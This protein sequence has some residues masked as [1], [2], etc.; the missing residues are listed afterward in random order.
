MGDWE[1][2]LEKWSRVGWWGIFGQ[3]KKFELYVKGYKQ[4]WDDFKEGDDIH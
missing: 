2:K 3:G 1:M 4:P